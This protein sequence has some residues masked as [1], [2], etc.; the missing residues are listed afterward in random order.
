MAESQRFVLL[1]WSPLRYTS[2]LGQVATPIIIMVCE[3]ISVGVDRWVLH[4][5]RLLNSWQVA[6]WP[7]IILSLL[8]SIK[9]ENSRA[10]AALF[11][12]GLTMMTGLTH[13]WKVHII[14]KTCFWNNRIFFFSKYWADI[15]FSIT[16]LYSLF[17]PWIDGDSRGP[18]KAI[19]TYWNVRPS[20]P[21]PSKCN[22]GTKE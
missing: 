16:F 11:H 13:Y 1:S 19:P 18:T 20:R 9:S 3:Q 6:R 2:E 10:L 21:P 4:T 14:F 12:R 15:L 5:L 22:A 7:H 17:I 8:F